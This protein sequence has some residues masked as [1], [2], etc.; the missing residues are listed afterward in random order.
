MN[1]L[2]NIDNPIMQFISKIFDLVMLNLIF[3]LSC[4][5]VITVGASLSALYY[6]SLKILI[7]G[8]TFGRLSGR[9]SNRAPLCGYCTF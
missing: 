2:F 9:I 6:V 4:I 1:R 5:P 3:V 7:S 8:R